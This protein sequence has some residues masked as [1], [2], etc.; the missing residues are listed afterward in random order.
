M[1]AAP[2]GAGAA[3]VAVGVVLVRYLLYTQSG[4]DMTIAV[5]QNQVDL[6]EKRMAVVSAG[7]GLGPK[8]ILYA[9][10]A[11]VT[12]WYGFIIFFLVVPNSLVSLVL[13]KSRA[14]V[15][16]D[17]PSPFRFFRSPPGAG[18]LPAAA[19]VRLLSPGGQDRSL[20]QVQALL[21]DPEGPLVVDLRDGR[22]AG[23]GQLVLSRQGVSLVSG[24]VAC[25][26]G[27]ALRAKSC[28]VVGVTVEGVVGADSVAVDVSGEECRLARCRVERNAGFGVQVARLPVQPGRLCRA[29]LGPLSVRQLRMQIGRG[30][31]A[32]LAGCEA[33]D[34][35]A[36]GVHVSE[37]AVVVLE[38]CRISGNVDLGV[39]ASERGT[40]LDMTGCEIRGNRGT[41]LR[42]AEGAR[43]SIAKTVV[44]RNVGPVGNGVM[45]DGPDTAV[46]ITEGK[47]TKNQGCGVIATEGATVTASQC[48]SVSYNDSHQ[49]W[50]SGTGT[51]VTVAGGA[52]WRTQMGSSREVP[53]SAQ[54]GARI[55][56]S[57]GIVGGPGASVADVVG[58]STRVV[59]TDC[60]IADTSKNEVVAAVLEPTTYVDKSM[61]PAGGM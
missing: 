46:T 47:V 1:V 9:S 26:G 51:T 55:D 57:M 16:A 44:T 13:P 50:A 49:V 30:A 54:A 61:A 22:V 6:L 41:G 21:D 27:L 31:R 53:L 20:S 24:T 7:L 4:L 12:L 3:I 33:S 15:F 43:V 48:E 17:S 60:K 5:L 36:H 18:T 59:L 58:P 52:K 34:N 35:G 19:R 28:E 39:L 25:E 11:L 42:A 10:A 14:L 8:D 56:V 38:N 37:G 32:T 40:R 45:A 23:R 2:V 29:L